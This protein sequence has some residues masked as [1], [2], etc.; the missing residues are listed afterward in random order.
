MRLDRISLPNE[1]NPWKDEKKNQPSIYIKKMVMPFSFPMSI[2]KNMG[3]KIVVLSAM[4]S[5]VLV[6]KDKRK[7]PQVHSF[8]ITQKGALVWLI[9]HLLINLHT[10]NLPDGW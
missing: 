9:L 3:K 1:I 7:K 10:S 8:M 2:K 4:H 5:S 6:T